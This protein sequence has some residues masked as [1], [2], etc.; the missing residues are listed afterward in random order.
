[1]IRSDDLP[2]SPRRSS[3]STAGAPPTPPSTSGSAAPGLFAW[4][5]QGFSD[6]LGDRLL[7]FDNTEQS[8]LELLRLHSRLFDYPAFERAVRDQTQHL[9]ALDDP[10]FARVW[11]IER[12]PEPGGGIA[13][14]S[15]H[16]AG[17]RLS[18]VLA[19][20]ARQHA[21]LETV[22]AFL[23]IK[24][25]IAA[26]AALHLR[27]PE[28]V[29]GAI[30]P[31]R[32]VVTPEGRVVIHEYVLGPALGT[33]SWQPARFWRELRLPVP[34]SGQSARFDQ[35][36][37]CVQIGLVALALLLNR[38]LRLDEYPSALPSL[39]D[40]AAEHFAAAPLRP[41]LKTW[42]EKLLQIDAHSFASADQ[43]LTAFDAI[44]SRLRVPLATQS[45]LRSFLASATTQAPP[46][47]VAQATTAIAPAPAVRSRTYSPRF[48]TAAEVRSLPAGPAVV[49]LQREVRLLKAAVLVL[50]L[51]SLG[52]AWFIGAQ[53]TSTPR[54]E[55]AGAVTHTP[56]AAVTPPA[57]AAPTATDSV[58]NTSPQPTA[59]ATTASVPNPPAPLQS[60]R[61]ST[62]VATIGFGTETPSQPQAATPPDP[63]VSSPVPMPEPA[64]QL[65]TQAEL[66]DAEQLEVRNVIARFELAFNA[67]NITALREAYPT[68]DETILAPGVDEG[69]RQIALGACSYEVALPVVTAHCQ[70]TVAAG[71]LTTGEVS[72]ETRMFTFKLRKVSNAWQIDSESD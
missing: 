61:P 31:E 70:G 13:L 15:T 67:S 23:L 69:P 28:A 22:A 29:H 30:N 46:H 10:S 16:A 12:L 66:V 2:A 54:I 65:Q 44:L 72:T 24:Q 18:E 32:L 33:L 26:M 59:P 55:I 1:V 45:A 35:R 58:V 41:A 43:A 38:P 48:E 11:R 71:S 14:V 27:G 64:P 42:L 50:A 52:E 62:T 3:L 36:T 7:L 25:L 53:L 34:A 19:G 49:A 37:D 17:S 6:A 56:P 20:A 5:A 21:V 51:V 40:H 39:A 60:A 4:Y 9:A 57:T 68:A 8:A 63:G 47:A